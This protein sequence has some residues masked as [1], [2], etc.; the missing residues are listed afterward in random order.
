MQYENSEWNEN[1]STPHSYS[2]S[3]II[4]KSQKHKKSTVQV[5]HNITVAQVEL[6]I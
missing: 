5:Q 2:N 4:Q 1:E 6:H 3:I